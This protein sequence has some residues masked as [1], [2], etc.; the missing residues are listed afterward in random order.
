MRIRNNPDDHN[1]DDDP[2]ERR[3]PVEPKPIGDILAAEFADYLAHV[4]ANVPPPANPEDA[5]PSTPQRPDL[6]L[7]APATDEL[8]S[9]DWDKPFTVEEALQAARI[10]RRRVVRGAAG[11]SAVVVT[12]VLFAGW[13]EPLIV[14]GPL[15]VYGT[16][17]LAYLWWNAALRPSLGQV[18]A[19]GFGGV[20][21]ALTVVLTT[22]AALAHGLIGRV[23]AARDRHET[24]RTSP[25]TPSA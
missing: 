25:V 10:A 19:A 21:A 4:V 24:T 17:W 18:L 8:D 12:A 2:D 9:E 13:G 20:R 14:T 1:N 5:T 15:A 22:L 3:E 16:G 23:S 7:V 6:R 11:G